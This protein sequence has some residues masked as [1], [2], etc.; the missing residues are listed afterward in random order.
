MDVLVFKNT[1]M[2]NW[3]PSKRF[4]KKRLCKMNPTQVCALNISRVHP[5][6]CQ[7]H[8]V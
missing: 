2:S 5:S 4:Q 8:L 3:F 7:P 1:K 6:F